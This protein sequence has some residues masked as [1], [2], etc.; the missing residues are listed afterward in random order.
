M[1]YVGHMK[2][3]LSEGPAKLFVWNRYVHEIRICV[4][5]Q[6]FRT[7]CIAYVSNYYLAS[8]DAILFHA[9]SRYTYSKTSSKTSGH[10]KRTLY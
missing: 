4:D 5:Q 6:G 9:V 8:L 7:I 2:S 10:Q 3:E 1:A